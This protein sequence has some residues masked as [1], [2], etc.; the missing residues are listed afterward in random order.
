MSDKT[1]SLAVLPGDG[2]GPEVMVEAVKVLEA[3]AKKF[4]FS[5]SYQEADF[6][7]I[8]YDRH[9]TPLPETTRE[10]CH[11]VDAIL[12][13]SVGGPK[14]DGLPLE[15]RPEFGGLIPLRK[16]LNLYA[17]LRPV[18]LWPG[19]EECCPLRKEIIPN[20]FDM[21]TVRELAGGIYYGEPKWFDEEK[22]KGVDTMV[23]ERWEVERI[24]RIGFEIART[25][26][27]RIIS[28]D[29]SNVLMSMRAWRQSVEE[30]GKEYPDVELQHMLFDNAAM[31]VLINPSQFDVILGS[32]IVGDTIS[33]ET[34]GLAGSLGLL[35]STSIGDKIN[36]YEPAGGSAPDIAGKG[37]ANPIAQILSAAMM[38]EHS[39]DEKEAADAIWSAIEKALAAGTRTGDIARNVSAVSTSEM[40]DAIAENL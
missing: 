35:P 38:L 17:N 37:I 40:G 12:L 1:Y 18:R 3:A 32:N 26:K 33:D 6:G 29:K 25:R 8:A 24:A 2:I 23:Y 15:K 10:L 4:G 5:L 36:L 31:Q 14:W 13:G 21:I 39:F 22:C 30:V 9:E 28:I 19:L 11:N 20:G 34:A 27:K 7:G 16:D